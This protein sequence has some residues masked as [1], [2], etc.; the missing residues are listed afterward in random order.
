MAKNIG[1]KKRS[2]AL[3]VKGKDSFRFLNGMLSQDI[4]KSAERIPSA[5]R[6]FFLTNK[7]KIIAPLYFVSLKEEELILWTEES[8]A[9]ALKEGLERY[10]IADKVEIEALGS[11]DSW[12][13]VESE[14][15][16]EALKTRHPL[17]LEKLFAAKVENDAFVVPQGRLSSTHVEV[18]DLKQKF[19]CEEMTPENYWLKRFESGSPEW[20]TDFFRDDFFL[21]FPFGD[22]VSFDKGCYVGQETVAR[23][24]FRGKVNKSYARIKSEKKLRAGEVTNEAGDKV[25]TIRS[26]QQNNG[27]GIVKF[28]I[29]SSGAFFVN[30]EKHA[31]T[32]EHLVSEETFRKGR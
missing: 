25:G 13:L 24:T 30:G 10:I 16:F 29:Q 2:A 28:D 6:A 32:I 22:A 31:L 5:S 19:N 11:F 3:R 8:A 27:T 15:T 17:G 20:G 1:I 26:V 7:G 14:F 12:S 23:G 18:L 9:S 21:E 4:Q